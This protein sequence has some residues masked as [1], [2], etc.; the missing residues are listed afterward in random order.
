MTFCFDKYG[1]DF[2]GKVYIEQNYESWKI[3]CIT[4]VVHVKVA[5]YVSHLND[6]SL[7][8]CMKYIDSNQN[9][10]FKENIMLRT[11]AQWLS[12][13]IHITLNIQA[14]D[15]GWSSGGGKQSSEYRT[16]INM[17]YNNIHIK[18]HTQ[19]MYTSGLVV[20]NNQ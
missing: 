11:Y 15:T 5:Q 8:G 17:D 9:L 10:L 1:Y 6:M 20:V 4:L 13:C 12:N 2:S 7:E 3:N 18:S 16:E 19:K 14:I